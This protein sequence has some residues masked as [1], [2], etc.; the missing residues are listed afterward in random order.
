MLKGEDELGK[1]MSIQ[2]KKCGF[3][4]TLFEGLGNQTKDFEIFRKTLNKKDNDFIDYILSKGTIKEIK[5][6]DSYAKCNKC[7]DLAT[8]NYVEIKYDDKCFILEHKCHICEGTYKAIT[9]EDLINSKCP[10]CN[11]D[12]FDSYMMIDWD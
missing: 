10:N 8:I 3:S 4:A 2:C 9:M 11:Y 6:R 5:Y 1:G 7:G 12:K